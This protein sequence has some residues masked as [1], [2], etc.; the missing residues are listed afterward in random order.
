[1]IKLQDIEIGKTYTFSLTHSPKLYVGLVR[2][3]DEAGVSVQMTGTDIVIR[4]YVTAIRSIDRVFD[5]PITRTERYVDAYGSRSFKSHAGYYTIG[6]RT[7]KQRYIRRVSTLAVSWSQA[8]ALCSEISKAHP[9]LKVYCLSTAQSEA[10]GHTCAEDAGNY[11]EDNGR[12]IQVRDVETVPSGFHA[13][14]LMRTHHKLA[15]LADRWIS[16]S[17]RI[18]TTDAESH[19]DLYYPNAVFDG[20]WSLIMW[21]KAAIGYVMDEAHTEA[22][23]RFPAIAIVMDHRTPQAVR[24]VIRP[25]IRRGEV[26]TAVQYAV[27]VAHTEALAT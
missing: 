5:I 18:I 23:L 9:E 26:A 22:A 16:I 1:M 3:V 17:D 10:D 15:A 8:Y 25:M 6:Y 27:D 4:L 13:E 12:R 24:S 19:A 21:Y 2:G 11:L 7:P 14:D 20:P